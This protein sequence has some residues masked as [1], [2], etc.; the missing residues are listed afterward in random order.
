MSVLLVVSSAPYGSE[1]PF[2]AFRFADARATRDEHVGVFLAG[3]A[4]TFGKAHQPAPPS[5]P[6]RSST[7][8][9]PSGISSPAVARFS[10]R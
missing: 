10:R 7:A 2:N 5:A 8:I 9:I 6:I 4:V 1:G 3:D